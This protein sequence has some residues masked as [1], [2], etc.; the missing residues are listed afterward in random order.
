MR[1]LAEVA[2]FTDDV[3]ATSAFY[4]QLLDAAP[5]TAWP[6]GATFTAGESTLLVH[7]RPSSREDGPPGEDHLGFAVR[8][9]E[10]A[11][12][13]LRAAG[14]TLLVEPRTYDWGRSAYLRDPE[15][16]LVELLEPR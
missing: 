3:V 2:L 9:L 5:T 1:H 7:E 13:A 11:C 6:G 15:G 10:L 16:R 8:D 4:A 14:V 12:A